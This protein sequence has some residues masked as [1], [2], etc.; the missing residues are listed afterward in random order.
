MVPMCGSWLETL[1][2]QIRKVV[3][4]IVGCEDCGGNPR[5]DQTLKAM[6]GEE[7]YV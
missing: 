1:K 2:I 4:E 7:E 3:L 5:V 6:L